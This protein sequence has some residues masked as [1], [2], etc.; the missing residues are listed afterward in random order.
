MKK[1]VT[2]Q[3]HRQL[4]CS[5]TVSLYEDSGLL[6][7]KDSDLIDMIKA[8]AA[9]HGTAFSVAMKLMVIKYL[10]GIG[11][12]DTAGSIQGGT[13]ANPDIALAAIQNS[14]ESGNG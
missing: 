13:T 7:V 8:Y 14:G 12:G 6:G 5:Y 2:G 1:K 10:K 11:Y 9:E 4:R 3:N